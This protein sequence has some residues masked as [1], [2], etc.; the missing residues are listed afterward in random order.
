[1]TDSHFDRRDALK[2]MGVATVGYGLPA[3][4][5]LSL[6]RWLARKQTQERFLTDAEL[7][8]VRVL[9]DM[10]IP[11]DDKSGS[12]SDAGVPQYVDFILAISDQRSQQQWRDGLRWF[13]DESNRRFTMP[14]TQ[15]SDAQR[16]Q[17]L[18]DIAFPARARAEFQAPAAFFN[19]VRDLV[20]SGFFSSRMGVQDLGYVGGVFNPQWNG[21]P[22]EALGPLGLNY[23]EWDRRY[24]PTN[25]ANPRP[26]RQGHGEE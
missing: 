6:Q 15:A 13:N 23:A 8:L 12:A 20:A 19:R 5:G 18:D 3:K 14:F 26:S 1:M 9:G 4:G 22:P 16:G 17:I 10:L 7:A 11:R 21:A 25:S 2:A 24:G